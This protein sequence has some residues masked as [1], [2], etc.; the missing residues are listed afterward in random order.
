[1]LYDDYMYMMKTAK[2]G[3]RERAVRDKAAEAPGISGGEL[4]WSLLGAG[5]GGGLGY[6]IGGL[7]GHRQDR[8]R[9]LIAALLGAGVGGIGAN[10]FMDA[11]K[12]EDGKTLRHELRGNRADRDE[13]QKAIDAD[14]SKDI[15]SSAINSASSP[16]AV[17]GGA[18]GGILGALGRGLDFSGRKM[19]RK[20]IETYGD[21]LTTPGAVAPGFDT[22]ARGG[23]A[24][25]LLAAQQIRSKPMLGGGTKYYGSYDDKLISPIRL[26]A[27]GRDLGLNAVGGW[28]LGTGADMARKAVKNQFADME[29]K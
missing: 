8:K 16:L 17:G 29:G 22:T 27:I 9:R 28:L 15:L 10:V 12:N 18:A 14:E 23:M 1:M 5:A 26:R 11:Y 13:L 24:G 20:Y 3:R 6:L 25:E 21:K 4:L 2:A 19:V 7:G